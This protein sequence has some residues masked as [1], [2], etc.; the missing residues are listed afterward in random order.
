MGAVLTVA[1]A[2]AATLAAG[3]AGAAAASSGGL[4]LGAKLAAAV[5]AAAV[6]TSGGLAATGTLPDPAQTFVADVAETVSI[7]LP[8]PDGPPSGVPGPDDAPPPHRQDQA[9]RRERPDEMSDR[10][11]QREI[12]RGRPDTVVPDAPPAEDQRPDGRVS[13]DQRPDE[14]PAD[15]APPSAPHGDK[16]PAPEPG[17]R[18]ELQEPDVTP[19]AEAPSP[20]VDRPPAGA[21]G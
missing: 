10:N 17:E 6:V 9:S 14:V 15:E 5:G 21:G 4:L 18:D 12:E 11:E 8:R 20:P 13:D 19:P 16:A 2:T 1:G 7:E 3:G